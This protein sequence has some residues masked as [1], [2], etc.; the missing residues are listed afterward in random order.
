MFLK[1]LE[2]FG[3]DFL[4]EKYLMD[5]K[6]YRINPPDPDWDGTTTMTHK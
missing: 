5:I 1:A 4:T 3:E 2:I 6:E